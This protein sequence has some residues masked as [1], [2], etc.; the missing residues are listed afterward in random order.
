M[1]KVKICGL[2]REEDI[3]FINII[4]PDYVGFIIDFPKSHRSIDFKKAQ[5]LISKVYKNIKIVCVFVDKPI[6]SVIK[7]NGVCDIVQLHGAED[8]EYIDNIRKIDS[9]IEIWKAFK[10]KSE[11]DLKKAINSNA[12]KIL[13]DNGYGTGKQ[14]DWELINGFGR[15]FILAGGINEEN[16]IKAI[17]T[18]K[19]FAVDVSSC[20]ETNKMKDFSKI[21]KLINQVEKANK[22]EI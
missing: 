3:N 15:E 2:Y 16:V 4:K 14:F 17:D 5:K 22:K 11:E 18:Y 19:P 9:N 1:T 10:I 20:V 7:Y 6:D 21:E 8:N 13:L 12:D